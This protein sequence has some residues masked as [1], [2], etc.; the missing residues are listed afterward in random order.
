MKKLLFPLALFLLIGCLKQP[1]KE[2]SQ[3]E[4][5]TQTEAARKADS[6]INFSKKVIETRDLAQ[7]FAGI[8]NHL[9]G[10]GNLAF[11]AHQDPVKARRMMKNYAK[12]AERYRE[13]AP[14]V[15]EARRKMI[16]SYKESVKEEE[17]RIY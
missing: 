11:D 4:K 12:L 14:K 13:Y 16:Q 7:S 17:A 10:S 3:E 15:E 6:L 2:L 8:H 5:A 1:K 9:M